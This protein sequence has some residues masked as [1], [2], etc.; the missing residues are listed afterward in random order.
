MDA[1]HYDRR[2][3]A[4]RREATVWLTVYSVVALFAA[5]LFIGALYQWTLGPYANFLARHEDR[6]DEARAF[7]AS[8]T[9]TDPQT[10]A[11]ANRNEECVRNERL[12]RTP[13]SSLAWEDLLEHWALCK[14]GKCHVFGAD[15]TELV[16][17]P[18]FSWVTRLSALL[19]VAGALGLLTSCRTRALGYEQM[20]YSMQGVWLPPSQPHYDAHYIDY[21]KKQ[22]EPKSK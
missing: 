5:F 19:F 2:A 18:A 13:A 12:A 9:C 15:V 17:V 16:I 20:P 3:Q 7:V 22:L 11:R 4:Q 21:L 1:G 14:H 10:R 8:T 6:I